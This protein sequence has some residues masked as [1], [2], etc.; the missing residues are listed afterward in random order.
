MDELFQKMCF[1]F[2]EHLQAWF[3]EMASQ[4]TSLSYD[5][6]TSAGR[7]ITQLIAALD[8]VCECTLTSG[9]SFRVFFV[10]L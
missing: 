6:S 1:L 4:I 7:K 8:E 2:V 5:D 9:K 10:E 3:T